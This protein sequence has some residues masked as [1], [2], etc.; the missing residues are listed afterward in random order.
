MKKR[1]KKWLVCLLVFFLLTDVIFFNNQQTVSAAVGEDFSVY[2]KDTAR[3]RH[4]KDSTLV[5][6]VELKGVFSLG[7]SVSQTIAV[8][9][10]FYVVAA[11]PNKTN[12]FNLDAGTY[13]YKIP[14]DFNFFKGDTP[15][16]EIVQMLIEKGAKV[17]QLGDYARNYSHP[18]Y[19]S[20][21]DRFYVGI[22]D[23][24]GGGKVIALD[25][26][27]NFK[28]AFP[29]PTGEN[30][31]G[32]PTLLQDDLVAIGAQDGK[33][34]VINGLAASS[35]GYEMA[36][37]V[38][39]SAYNAEV[40]GALSRVS[41]T[42]LVFGYNIRS[43]GNAAAIYR[44][45][46]FLDANNKLKIQQRWRKQ[47]A[48]GIPTN[49][50][51][52]VPNGRLY[53]TSKYGHVYKL[54]MNGNILS[55]KQIDNVTLIN[56]SLAMD[57]QNIYIPVRRPGK[58]VAYRKSDMA[59]LFV[60]Q[61]GRDR[62]GNK[63]DSDISTGND[64]SNNVMIW[65]EN[66]NKR[67]FYGDTEGQV[68]FLTASGSRAPV[69]VDHNNPDKLRS[70]VRGP[71]STG[72]G[73]WMVQG[74][75]VATESMIAKQH[76]AFGINEGDATGK[77]GWLWVYSIGLGED[78]YV[79]SVEGGT[80]QP[81]EQILTP[82][83]VGSK[84]PTTKPINAIVRLYRDNT[85]IDQKTVNIKPDEERTVIFNWSSNTPAT[86]TLKATINIPQQF[87]EVDFTNNTKTAPYKIIGDPPP[88]NACKPGDNKL[89]G[90][91][92][93]EVICD[94]YGCSTIYYYEFLK[95]KSSP[96][97]PSK[98]RAG[99]GFSFDS[100]AMYID[101]YGQYRG[102][103]KGNVVFEGL[104]NNFIEN[105]QKLEKTNQD[106][107]WNPY[108]ETSTWQ[109][110]KVFV[111]KYSGNLFYDSSD[112]RRDTKDTLLDGG[113]KWYTNFK[114]KDGTYYFTVKISEAGKNNLSTCNT[115]PFTVKGTP[116]DDF[117]RRDVYPTQ[118]FLDEKGPGFN[119]KGKESD[120][121]ELVPFY[122]T[123]ENEYEDKVD[124][125]S[126]RIKELKKE[127]S[128]KYS[129]KSADEFKKQQ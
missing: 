12:L 86:G 80:Y 54:D 87:P 36:S 18:T 33:V 38:A 122:Q 56:N 6:P 93:I 68:T 118:P 113:R 25:G 83:V 2:G 67:I 40:S 13:M 114:E 96:A 17:V 43:S 31:V 51:Y 30:I 28:R 94:E 124:L 50:I 95:E 111:E 110:P 34:Y 101:E 126:G 74:T 41:P 70:S 125:D 69:A 123:H 21:T 82:V 26:N 24:K 84:E 98:V 77:G 16:S 15:R 45:S 48:T 52:D 4:V 3:T 128:D 39:S 37:F 5:P 20:S 107:Q 1:I 79:K 117:V 9:D 119:W 103:K 19:A 102:P 32:P 53:A 66:G 85:L 49:V 88:T 121:T 42:D 27:L 57:E 71:S 58:V 78:V 97:F 60:A 65:E 91:S 76:L 104:P 92:K 10:F 62:G 59:N 112:S 109:L 35:G 81:G 73:S 7:W 61:Q 129:K 23:P 105:N 22:A 90:V 63:V 99:Y 72:S 120:I 44:I 46:A 55:Q 116:F 64:V 108:T 75:G 29:I 11:V 8:G 89:S 115:Y 106:V 100:Y 14:V 127:P 47:T